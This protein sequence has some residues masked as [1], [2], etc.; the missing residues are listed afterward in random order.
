VRRASDVTAAYL[1]WL[2]DGP[3]PK[4]GDFRRNRSAVTFSSFAEDV[5]GALGDDHP[6]SGRPPWTELGAKVV[7][8]RFGPRLHH[9]V[10]D[11]EDRN[12]CRA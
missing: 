7:Q 9:R 10:F 12:P 2:P 1:I 6:H 5:K 11:V 3:L 4:R 8:S